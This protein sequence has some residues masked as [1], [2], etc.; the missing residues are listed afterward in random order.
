MQLHIFQ[1]IFTLGVLLAS[2]QTAFCQTDQELSKRVAEIAEANAG[3]DNFSGSVLLA[4]NGNIVYEKSFGFADRGKSAPFFDT[5]ASNIASVG[6]MLTSVLILQLVEEKKL[7][8][9][10]SIAKHL[11]NTKIP[12]ADKITVHHLLTHTSGLGTY[13]QHP[14]YP[15]LLKN[16]VEVDELVRLIEQQQLVFAEPGTRFEYSNSGYIVL[17]KIIERITGKR[18]ADVLAEKIIKPLDLKNTRLEINRSD[19]RGLAKGHLKPTPTD[20]WQSNEK[21][22][23]TPSSDGGVYAT[24]K[25]LF[26]FNQ[27]LLGGKLLNKQSLELMKNRHAEMTV[28]GLG[29]MNYGYA[30]M[31][32]NYANDFQ[33]IGHNGGTPGYGA[34][35]QHY[36]NN[37]DEFTLI[38]L[39]NYDRRVRGLM[40]KIQ[41]EILKSANKQIKI[42]FENLKRRN[43]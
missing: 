27:A 8:L 3:G 43:G 28:P 36:S 5:T 34:E 25:D 40:F 33:S 6:K 32:Q 26:R 1:F 7:L 31:I 37:R 23:P 38:I 35:F 20:V 10:D 42:S 2:V 4:K 11:P 41:E 18:Y 17:G 30:V 39:S 13:W 15:K 19:F 29:K 9:S 16:A 24:A 21:Q 22:M 14:D 12:N